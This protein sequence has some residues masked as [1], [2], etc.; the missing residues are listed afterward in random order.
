M[1]EVLLQCTPIIPYL[2][3]E[4]NNAFL[5]K[6][7]AAYLAEGREPFVVKVAVRQFVVPQ[8]LPHLY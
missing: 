2:V 3:E 7:K 5:N 1:V 8:K 6:C 4:E